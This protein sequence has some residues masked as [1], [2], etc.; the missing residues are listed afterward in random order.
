MSSI[1]AISNAIC[2]GLLIT[3]TSTDIYATFISSQE[4]Q[5]PSTSI[6]SNVTI[7]SR[8]MT[9]ILL[10]L[11]LLDRSW[12]FSVRTGANIC[13]DEPLFHCHWR[14]N[15]SADL[16]PN[17]LGQRDQQRRDDR[18]QRQRRR[19]LRHAGEQRKESPVQRRH[20]QF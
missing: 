3:P 15:R 7:T 8:M 17:R 10:G 13:V 2:G 5:R 20:D 9:S 18:R 12:T 1:T 11:F 14:Q 6:T 19:I 4:L 16:S